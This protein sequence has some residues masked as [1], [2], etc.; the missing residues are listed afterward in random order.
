MPRGHRAR[1]AAGAVVV[2]RTRP[3]GR[4]CR[5]PSRAAARSQLPP[6]ADG[7]R[8]ARVRGG[9]GGRS[10]SSRPSRS[11]KGAGGKG[12]GGRGRGKGQRRGASPTRRLGTTRR[13]LTGR[14]TV[15]PCSPGRRGHNSWGPTPGGCGGQGAYLGGDGGGAQRVTGCLTP[16]HW[17]NVGKP[18]SPTNHPPPRLRVGPR[19]QDR[20]AN[21]SCGLVCPGSAIKCHKSTPSMKLR[22]DGFVGF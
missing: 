7:H 8:D 12:E 14:R 9:S 15:R 1:H 6:S 19:S 20:V 18:P 21:A 13:P 17:R 4:H 16:P 11:A 2:P 5:P 3:R 22:S 10:P